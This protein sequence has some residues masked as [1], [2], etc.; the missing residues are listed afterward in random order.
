[1]SVRKITFGSIFNKFVM[2]TIILSISLTSCSLPTKQSSPTIEPTSE[3]KSP[4][5][6]ERLTLPPV[7][8]GATPLPGSQIGA[9]Q[10]IAI[11]FNQPMDKESVEAAFT[12]EPTVGGKF[13]WQNEKTIT[14]TPDS[15]FSLDTKINISVNENAKAQNGKNLQSPISLDYSIAGYLMATTVLP[16]DGSKEIDPVSSIAVNFNQPVVALGK[17]DPI[18]PI[19]ITPEVTGSGEWINTSTYIFRPEPALAGGTAYTI[20]LKSDVTSALGAPLSTDSQSKWSFSTAAPRILSITPSDNLLELQGPITINF[21]IRMD[22]TSVEQAFALVSAN[23][24]DLPGNFAW[25][26]DQTSLTF[27][28]TSLLERNANY[29]VLID[30]SAQ[31]FGGMALGSNYRQNLTTYPGLEIYPVNSTNFESY[32]YGYGQLTLAFSAPVDIPSAYAAIKVS[33]Q[34]PSSYFYFS[35]NDTTLSIGGYFQPATQYTVT[36]GSQLKDKWG[37]KLAQPIFR[38]FWTPD[39]EPSFSLTAISYMY[40]NNIAFRPT[41]Q[42]SL[43]AQA[44]N[45]TS[46]T[47]G[48]GTMSYKDFLWLIDSDI[49]DGKDTYYPADYREKELTFSLPANKTET[50]QIPLQKDGNW[51][52]PGIYYVKLSSNEARDF[53]YGS[54][55]KFVLIVSDYN[56]ILK[57]S[58]E[59]VFLWVSDISNNQGSAG[60]PVSILRDDGTLLT[61][62]VTDQEGFFKS[63]IPFQNDL[64]PTYFAVIGDTSNYNNFALGCTRWGSNFLSWDMGLDVERMPDAQRVYT[65]TDRPIYRPGQQVFF[66]SV[67]RDMRNGTYILPVNK[68]FSIEAGPGHY[69]SEESVQFYTSQQILSSFGSLSGDFTIPISTTPGSYSIRIYDGEIQVDEIYF[70]VAN[71]RKPEI[72]MNVSLA[73]KQVLAGTYI[74]GSVQIDYYFGIPAANLEA[75]WNLY[76]APLSFSLPGY[77]TGNLDQSWMQPAHFENEFGPAGAYITSGT[78]KTDANGNLQLRIPAES[79]QMNVDGKQ[80]QLTLESN[81]ADASGFMLSARDTMLVHPEKFYIGVKPEAY[82]SAA[83]TPVQFDLKTVDWQSDSVSGVSLTA[84]FSQVNWKITGFEG[85]YNSPIYEMTETVIATASPKTS[86]NGEAR[87]SFTSET[88]GTYLLTISSGNAS[89]QVLVWV[90]GSTAVAWPNLPNAR[91]ELI[92]DKSLYQVGEKARVFIPNPF[93]QGAKALITIERESVFS[94]DLITIEGA[95]VYYDYEIQPQDIPNVYFSVVLYN[96]STDS[97]DYRQ[98]VINLPVDRGQRLL[99]VTVQVTPPITR[100]AKTVELEITV[101]D[102]QGQPIRGEFSVAIIDKAI[103]ALKEATELSIQDAFYGNRPN[104]VLSGLSIASYATLTS[105]QPVPLGGGG[106]GEDMTELRKDFPDTALWQANII[107]GADGKALLSVPL[108]DNL[109]TWHI[110]VRGINETDLVGEAE[111]EIVTQKELMIR[112]QTPRFLVAGD[113]LEMLAIVHNNTSSEQQVSVSLQTNGFRLD[114]DSPQT[115]NVAIKASNQLTVKWKGVVENVAE[116]GLIFSATAGNLSD[117]ATPTWGDL[118][119][120]RYVTPLNYTTSGQLTQAGSRIEVVSLPDNFTPEGGEL[121]IELSPSLLSLLLESCEAIQDLTY[122]DNITLA[123]KLDANVAAYQAYKTIGNNNE[124]ILNELTTQVRVIINTLSTNKNYDS[125]WGW[126]SSSN[127]FSNSDYFITMVVFQALQ[128]AAESGFHINTYD[129]EPVKTYLQ[130]NLAYPIDNTKANELNFLSYAIFALDG[131]HPQN[132]QIVSV[133]YQNRTSLSAWAKAML[134]MTISSIDS[135]DTRIATLLSDLEASA[136]R[137][138]TSAHWQSKGNSWTIPEST[139]FNSAVSSFTIAKLN[140][141]ST[142]LSDGLRYLTALRRSDHQWASPFES[143]WMIRA[144]TTAAIGMGDIQANY[145]FSAKVNNVQVASVESIDPDATNPVKVTIPINQLHPDWPNGVEISRTAGSGLLYYRSDLLLYQPA[146]TALPLEKGMYLNRQYY[147]DDGCTQDCQPIHQVSYK[148]GQIPPMV[149]VKLTMIIPEDMNNIVIEDF[150]PSG[151]EIF[152]PALLT[153]PQTNESFEIDYQQVDNDN[154]GWWFFNQPS[155]YNDHIQWTADYLPAGTYTISYK[156][157]PFQTGQFQVI[158]AHTW[159][160]YFPEVE[161]TSAGAIFEI[162]KK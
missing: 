128:N 86:A 11:S 74:K 78:Q 145:G 122:D 13:S 63:A 130:D 72:D 147:L 1:M 104:S 151:T 61:N 65:Y 45:I 64:Y 76:A 35:D 115:Q 148:E 129:L 106:G 142:L 89:T 36:L 152:D 71:Y 121:T 136:S 141:A 114:Q 9:A 54:E 118:P 30:Q 37:A 50:I 46:L 25:N 28:P 75:T 82:F 12:C 139:G 17:S 59:E 24:A 3:T 52:A 31:S 127:R 99:N 44:I 10:P 22:K 123:A 55:M 103:L 32:S 56:S 133:L 60:L 27:T 5:V 108:P 15:P 33:P 160:F 144:I 150:I 120:L 40:A 80:L 42:P 94:H 84:S 20:S 77:Q 34:I 14:F 107:T 19:E 109:T 81:T 137:T 68:S 88:P 113:H 49:Y 162:V 134:A 101:K 79:L 132:R 97:A 38:S 18:I 138:A 96:S 92:A 119:V 143:A 47:L 140:P 85:I 102:T 124:E 23:N 57:V 39:A 83:G 16:I 48:I 67:L 43:S 58:A 26:D 112:P 153:S 91:I 146:G 161:A 69:G 98:G 70:Q 53:N 158:P 157:L 135:A 62:G 2:I 100:P 7:L 126:S 149:T 154:W 159:Q 41:G 51:L 116:V 131:D 155:I 4:P 73:A 111:A 90:S 21:N 156:V 110:T 125:G 93:P 66:K 105:V 117:A 87:L 8:M 29:N 6:I 95:G